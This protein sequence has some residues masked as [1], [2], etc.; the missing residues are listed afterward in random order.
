MTTFKFPGREDETE[1]E[2]LPEASRRALLSRVVGHFNNEL[3]AAVIAFGR[4]AVAKS[5]GNGAKASDVDTAASR[6][7]RD[8]HPDEVKKFGNAWM[9]AKFVQIMDGTLSARSSS[10]VVVSPLE[11]EM[12]KIAAEEIRAVFDRKGWKFPRGEE[13]F[14]AGKLVLNREGWIDRWLNH[15]NDKLIGGDGKPNEPRI[16]AAAER[17]LR[18]KAALFKRVASVEL[19]GDELGL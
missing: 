6:T 4:D 15:S 8:E 3:S 17:N 19:E 18:N 1:F 9:A 12:L 14:P 2:T 10:G 13:T 7:Y 16:R 11:K 5:R